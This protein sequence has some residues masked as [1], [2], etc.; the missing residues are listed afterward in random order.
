MKSSTFA[1]SFPCIFTVPLPVSC[2]SF[3]HTFCLSP[4]YFHSS[5]L[6]SIS[7]ALQV[8]FY[9]FLA[10]AAD[11]NVIG[12]HHRPWSFLSDLILSI[13]FC[14]QTR[15]Q[16]RSLVQS[17]LHLETLR[18]SY[19]APHRCH[20]NYLVLFSRTSLPIETFACNTTPLLLVPCR[21]YLQVDKHTMHLDTLNANNASVEHFLG[22]KPY[23]F[24]ERQLTPS[25]TLF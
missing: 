25:T 9:M 16:S 19:R 12:K 24:A 8:L 22:M 4:C 23:V 11:H 6:Q 2:L 5:F 13:T 20:H 15:A 3:T 18:H 7:P 17:Y 14:K 1:T 10:L 21:G